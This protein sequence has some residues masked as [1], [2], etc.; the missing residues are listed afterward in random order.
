M[1][2]LHVADDHTGFRQYGSLLRERDFYSVQS[3]IT[4]IAIEHKVDAV[5]RAGDIWDATKPPADAVDCIQV[6]TERL[7][8][9]GIPTLGIAGNHDACGNAW[10][11]V[12][13]I[14]SLDN[15]PWRGSDGIVI[16]GKHFRR[17]SVFLDEILEER[18]LVKAD[19]Y[20]IHQA[21]RELCD[22]GGEYLSLEELGPAFADMGVKYV[23]M[24][25]IHKSATAVHTGVTFSYPGSPERKST[26]DSGLKSVNIVTIDPITKEVS[27]E[28]I[29]LS[30]R[31]F[32]KVIINTQEDVD[33]LLKDVAGLNSD[34]PVIAI[35]HGPDAKALVD[36]A[37]GVLTA[38]DLIFRVYP[39]G[40]T[41]DTNNVLQ[42]ADEFSRDDSGQ[43]LE[44]VVEGYFDADTVESQVI[45]QLL[46]G[47]DINTVVDDYL[48]KVA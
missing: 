1:K 10:L 36:K 13:G 35:Y 39:Q 3:Q 48:G 15:N 32:V 26:D 40:T 8:A 41:E 46:V 18:N 22:Y 30:T 44:A 37:E 11:S 27:I 45:K 29:P 28:T 34:R 20:V 33:N 19:V 14:R 5:I 17:S 24:G 47:A 21:V 31:R 43:L 4:D 6:E 9:A 23:G 38:A 16:T 42:I 7:A 25:D 12:C 2:F